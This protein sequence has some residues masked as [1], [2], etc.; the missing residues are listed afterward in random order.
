MSGV[1]ATYNIT[2]D[3]VLYM[4]IALKSKWITC[5]AVQASLTTSEMWNIVHVESGAY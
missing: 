1:F 2:P 3:E 5:K 4:N